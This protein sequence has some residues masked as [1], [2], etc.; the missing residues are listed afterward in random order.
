MD[1]DNMPKIKKLSLIKKLYEEDNLSFDDIAQKLGTYANKIRRY[2]ISN[3]IKIRNKSDAQKNALKTGKHKHPTKGTERPENVKNKIGLGVMN[4][5]D[6]ISKTEKTKRKNIAKNNWN[7]LSED[8]KQHRQKIANEAVRKT[9]KTGSKLEKFIFNKL[10]T[11][12]YKAGFHVEQVLSNTKLQI[13]ILLY[14]IDTAIEIDGP[15][16]FLPVWGKKN[17]EKNIKYDNKKE[18]LIIGKGMRLIRIKQKKD[19]SKTRAELIYS[20]L[21]KIIKDIEDNHI[22]DNKIIIED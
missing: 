6:N 5:W 9:S 15:S 11:D 7:K 8:E 14:N 3:G 22:T 10:L 13:D 18:G 19:F 16:H 21:L 17:L 2:A 12:G 20:N 1:Y 4:S